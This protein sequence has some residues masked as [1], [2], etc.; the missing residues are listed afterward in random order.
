MCSPVHESLRKFSNDRGGY[1]ENNSFVRLPGVPDGRKNPPTYVERG[2]QSVW[3]LYYNAD[4][5][6]GFLEDFYLD[7]V[8][9]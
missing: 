8:P 5:Y 2:A 7:D 4:T 3:T 1:Y 6:A 9:T